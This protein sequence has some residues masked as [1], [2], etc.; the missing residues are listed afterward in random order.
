MVFR[1]LGNVLLSPCKVVCKEG[2]S[3]GCVLE[4]PSCSCNI[5]CGIWWSWAND[6]PWS[7]A[8]T[9]S[10]EWIARSP[11]CAPNAQSRSCIAT[12]GAE[13][14]HVVAALSDVEWAEWCRQDNQMQ[15]TKIRSTLY[16]NRLGRDRNP[17]VVQQRC[18]DEAEEE[19]VK[20][21]YPIRPTLRWLQ[22]QWM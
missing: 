2:T 15:H 13:Q 17:W 1:N 20:L 19:Q 22:T 7:D 5:Q 18:K 21:S 14:A 8:K 9:R 4:L 16:I 11:G 12:T 10:C 3:T 6:C